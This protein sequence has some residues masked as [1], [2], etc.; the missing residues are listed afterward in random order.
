M[1]RRPYAKSA[2]AGTVENPDS[3]AVIT[4][5][6]EPSEETAAQ[7][8]NQSGDND[9][10]TALAVYAITETA[11]QDGKVGGPVNVITISPGEAGC[12]ALSVESVNEINAR[13][14]S[15]LQALRDSFY[16]RASN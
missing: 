4:V 11:G 2:G 7:T 6:N 3:A 15:R 5:S 1:A 9:E 14:A 16:E 8:P 12:Q 10:L 13:N